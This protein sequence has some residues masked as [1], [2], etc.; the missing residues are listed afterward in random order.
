[1]FNEFRYGA[2]TG[3]GPRKPGGS[4]A[5]P[6]RVPQRHGDGRLVE[7]SETARV[8]VLGGNG[9]TL[10]VANSFVATQ[11][12]G[13][14]TV[15]LIPLAWTPLGVAVGDT[16]QDVGV[17]LTGLVDWIDRTF[18][19]EDEQ[20]FVAPTRDLELLARIGW[21]A[22][23]PEQLGD[24]NVI[25]FDDLPEEVAEG[26]AQP[27]VTL[28][29]CAACRRLC[30][31]DEFVWKEKQLCAWDYHAQ[32][33]GKRGPWQ[34]GIYEERHF[35]TLPA[36]SYVAAPLLLEL[37]VEAIFTLAGVA[38][39]IARALVNALLEGDPGRSHMA[40]RADGGFT[41]LREA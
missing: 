21:N 25:N 3:G 28:V 24:A 8:V 37:G 38:E 35:E 34:T 10:A 23:L 29:Q 15:R 22:P 2:G 33:F 32:V 12:G 1:M 40:V 31:R 4:A 19:P 7:S 14:I 16:R 27:S 9:A 13:T 36:C 5:Q 41:V 6:A 30:V 26:L 20:A 11:P 18:A 39:E 17:P